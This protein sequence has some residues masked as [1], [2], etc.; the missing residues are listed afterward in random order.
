MSAARAGCAGASIPAAPPRRR[1]A[2]T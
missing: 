2:S 1:P